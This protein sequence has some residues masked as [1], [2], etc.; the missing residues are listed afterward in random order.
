MP[1]L[2]VRSLAVTPPAAMETVPAVPSNVGFGS[3]V[4]LPSADG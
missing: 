1:L 2:K 4:A 3:F